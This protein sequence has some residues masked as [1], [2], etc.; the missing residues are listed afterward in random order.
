[1]V[2]RQVYGR[3]IPLSYK[4][5]TVD[6]LVLRLCDVLQT[7]HIWT[8]YRRDQ[9]R[10]IRL[11]IVFED[12]RERAADRQPGPI[13]GMDKLCFRI[14]LPDCAL[15][16]NTGP[17]G[18]KSLKV[19]AGGDLSIVVLERKPDFDVVSLRRGEPHIAGTEG[20]DSVMQS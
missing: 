8:Q 14:F 10:P 16:S 19:A 7:S 1:M 11:L 17:P 13:E 5:M 20:D 18:L 4:G 3:K 15:I 9:H 6:V 2:K 12:G